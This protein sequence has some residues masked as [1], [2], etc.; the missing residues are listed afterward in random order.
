VPTINYKIVD[1]HRVYICPVC[2]NRY[3]TS[4]DLLRHRKTKCKKVSFAFTK[5]FE[6]SGFSHPGQFVEDFT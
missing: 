6:A 3:Y 1:G 5:D 2:K 4:G